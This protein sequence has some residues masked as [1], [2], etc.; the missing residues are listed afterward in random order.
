[1]NNLYSM[2]REMTTLSDVQIKILLH[3]RDA[4]SFAADISRNQVYIFTKGN[5]Q[6]V[7]VAL[8]AAKPIYTSGST[9]LREGD[10]FLKEEHVLID[11]VLTTGTCGVGKKELD[12]GH[13]VAIS[14]YPI[15]D[16]A[17]IPFAVAVFFSNSLK[18]QKI[19]TDTAY[20]A[21]QVPMKESDYK[22]LRPQDGM[23]I[24]D[25]VGRVM[26]ANDVA[27]DLYFILERRMTEKKDIIGNSM[28][29]FPLVDK[30]METRQSVYG[31]EIFGELTVS[32]WG[33]PILSRGRVARMVIFLSDITAIRE[34]ERQI[35]VKDSVI[36]EIHH[37]VKNSLNTVAGMLRM[38]ARRSHNAETKKALKIAVNRILGISQIHEIL[39]KQI[40]D[41][42]DWREVMQK[43]VQLS[44]DNLSICDVDLQM[45]TCEKPFYMNTEKV[46]PLAIAFNELVHNAIEHGFENRK[47]GKLMINNEWNDG[48]F[49]IK[50]I[51]DGNL[52]PSNFTSEQFDLGLQIV[53][54]L[55]EIE[56]KGS[57]SIANDKR[58]V[59]AI[60][61]CPIPVLEAEK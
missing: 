18:Q 28:I 58:G 51:N 19:L 45:T 20:M 49:Y 22:T 17:G 40:G 10:V 47:Q 41:K 7:F 52:L 16:N 39:A 27:E 9:F 37:R 26:Y 55:V 24:L 61:N 5:N 30:I 8:A 33:M 59:V 6:D 36:R 21:L 54:T 44:T 46:V 13:M 50:V 53:S 29:S 56:L 35:L 25:P 4:L 3:I 15:F 60:I 38:Q 14:A 43:T 31:E 57:F 42:I 48:K 32:A 11:H 12:L 23:V 2:A 34:K 1:M